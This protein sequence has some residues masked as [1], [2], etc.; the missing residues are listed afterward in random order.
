VIFSALVGWFAHDGQAQPCS[1]WNATVLACDG[2]VPGANPPLHT[3][4]SES[5]ASF[6]A[7]RASTA[8]L[9]QQKITLSAQNMPCAG[10]YLSTSPGTFGPQIQN[11]AGLLK[12]AAGVVVDDCNIWL[13]TLA[14]SNTYSP[15]TITIASDCNGGGTFAK[16]AGVPAGTGPLT[17]CAQLARYDS[18][19]VYAAANGIKIRLGFVPA[20][21]VGTNATSAGGCGLTPGSTTVAQYEPCLGPLIQ[22]AMLR[23]G[24]SIDSV[25]V[26]EE[27]LGETATI[28]TFTV[29]QTA[30]IISNFSAIVK[31]AVPGELVGAS[32]TGYSFP[33]AGT[34][35]G[36]GSHIDDCYWADAATG[37]ASSSLDF[38]VLDVFSGN[39]DQSGNYYANELGWFVSGNPPEGA[40]ITAAGGKPIRVGQTQT[41]NWCTVGGP[42]NEPAAI[43]GCGWNVWQTSGLQTSWETVFVAWASSYR[44]DVS[45]FFSLPMLNVTSS[46]TVNNCAT[47]GYT[48]LAMAG[49]SPQDA[50]GTWRTLGMWPRLG[51]GGTVK[52]GGTMKIQ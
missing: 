29:S 13:S 40:Y 34:P 25:Q 1:L 4:L 51:L 43:Q 48:A 38:L 2:Y 16:N 49:L 24:S 15:T 23:W 21:G 46:Q 8:H 33:V 6:T 27:P 52:L 42:P 39:C 17:R 5:Q 11:Y 10:A 36:G 32:Y 18:Y 26:L 19:F 30:S 12:S 45:M 41:P 22:A 44:M 14:S 28:Q 20:G 50:A 35:C 9:P 47:G 31:A 37:A 3:F 7:L